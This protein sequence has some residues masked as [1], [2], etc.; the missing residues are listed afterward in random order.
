MHRR[1][2][3]KLSEGES[4]I[5]KTE[6][7]LVK[8]IVV[9]RMNPLRH[10]VVADAIF[11]LI[12][13]MTARIRDEFHAVSHGGLRYIGLFEAVVSTMLDFHW[14]ISVTNSHDG[15]SAMEIHSGISFPNVEESIGFHHS[16]VVLKKYTY[17]SESDFRSLVNESIIE[18]R[19]HFNLEIERMERYKSIKLTEKDAHHIICTLLM[20]EIV[21][22]RLAYEILTDW[23][24][25]Q[26]D[27]IKP[28]TLW[29]LFVHCLTFTNRL[30]SIQHIER[31]KELHEFFDSVANFRLKPTHWVQSTFA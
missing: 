5:S 11:D 3:L 26:V 16:M 23:N 6:L 28:R 7:A 24:K 13:G 8:P 10:I 20:T 1:A 25:P 27:Y 4:S 21:A 22:G 14:V 9:N 18:C 2:N 19:M 17:T 29:S 30:K 31:S 12:S 15:K